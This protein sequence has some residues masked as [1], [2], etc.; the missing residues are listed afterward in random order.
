[1]RH[2]RPALLPVAVVLLLAFG[3]IAGFGGSPTVVSIARYD[4]ALGRVQAAVASATRHGG[5]PLHSAQPSVVSLRA[6][7]GIH[8]VS[9]GSGAVERVDT[10]TLLDAL[11]AADA[12]SSTQ[13]RDQAYNA[14]QRRI[15]FLRAELREDTGRTIA[16]PA[17]KEWADKILQGNAFQSAP[18]P[19]PTWF[20]RQLSKL[21][22]WWDG[23]MRRLFPNRPA[24]SGPVA[25]WVL[26][27]I[28]VVCAS[29][30]LALLAWI[31]WIIIHSH[32]Y[33]NRGARV[34][35]GPRGSI[36]ESLVEAR[37]TDRL[38]ALAESRA[39]DGD[40]RG[41][42]RMVYLATLVALDTGGVLR[43]DRSRTNWEY[44]RAL[45][46]TGQQEI[47]Q[48]LVPLTRDFDRVWYGFSRT[49]PD[50]YRRAR[51]EYDR[52]TREVDAR[53]SARPR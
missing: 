45:R 19:G 46:A 53:A 22:R 9:M 36:E 42:F 3:P 52:L 1:M 8:Y 17:Y 26:T 44:V 33:R 5:S 21:A 49:G 47:Y 14:I 7:G 29:L 25:P 27:A 11:A 13:A 15:R 30:A 51:D 24:A 40:Y 39:K 4:S 38:L 20:D 16:P 48:A 23:L 43:F 28:K 35:V 32:S 10:T 6:L 12:A 41:A 37:D 2:L 50:D 18:V 34:V 31:V